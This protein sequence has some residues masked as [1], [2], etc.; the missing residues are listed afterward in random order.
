MSAGYSVDT[1][2]VPSLRTCKLSHGQLSYREQGRGQTV[3][4]LHGLLG[5]SKSWALQF[6]RLSGDFRMVAWDAPGF[7]E[8]DPLPATIDAYVEALREFLDFLGEQ[9]VFLVGHSMGGTVAS[10][11]AALYPG[12]VARLVLSCTHPGYAD[13]E[14]APMSAKFENRMREYEELGAQVYGERRA[15]DLLPEGKA[16]CPLSVVALAAEV[17]SEV[18]PEGL[19]VATRML[20]LAD[21]RPL[22]PK[23]TAPTLILTGSVDTVVQPRLREDL[24]ALTPHEKHIDMPG[25]AHAPYFEAPDYY[26]DLISDFLSNK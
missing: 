20:Q 25:L 24:L 23:I 26:S 16:G 18:R 4:F 13:P 10:R 14:T 21:N 3:V 22:L 12:R 6:E 1:P 7:G 8:S 5:N 2:P 9:K 15:R 17:A 11:F 19:S